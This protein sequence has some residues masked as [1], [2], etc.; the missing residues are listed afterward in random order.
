MLNLNIGEKKKGYNK[1]TVNLLI[2]TPNC[3]QSELSWFS[4]S[5]KEKN[6]VWRLNKNYIEK[7]I[8]HVSKNMLTQQFNVFLLRNS[9]STKQMESYQHCDFNQI[10]ICFFFFRNVQ[11]TSWNWIQKVN[12][13]SLKQLTLEK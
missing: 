10:H 2:K 4:L 12:Q 7:K 3:N 13:V 5:N 9:S 6:K 8:F 11:L 1:E